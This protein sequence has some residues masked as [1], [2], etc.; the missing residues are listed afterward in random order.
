MKLKQILLLVI[1]LIAFST[2][3]Q[4]K[5][6]IYNGGE[7]IYSEYISEIDSITLIKSTNEHKY[8]DLGLSVK[9]AT[10]NVGANLPEE[11]GYYFAWGET[12]LKSWYDWGTYELC[13]GS[14][15]TMNEYC[16]KTS[17]GTIDNK[18]QLDL[19]DDAAHIYLGAN[20]RMPTKEE[21]DELRNA[22]NC[23]WSFETKNGVSG[24]SIKSKIN[25]N[26]IFLPITGYYNEDKLLMTSNGYYWSRT[27]YADYCNNARFLQLTPNN[28]SS[29][30]APRYYGY[31]IRPVYE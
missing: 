20:W 5:I 18:T 30:M 27:L 11:C 12:T 4:N 26:S 17:F 24:Y 10:C 19:E 22:N 13:N 16:N 31:P 23:E 29:S 3:A 15:V 2:A 1:L 14:R 7:L 8:V 6:E 28:T 25:G 9:W 21:Q